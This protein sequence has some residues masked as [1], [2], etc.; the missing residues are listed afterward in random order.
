MTLASRQRAEAGAPFADWI[1]PSNMSVQSLIDRFEP[2][3]PSLTRRLAIGDPHLVDFRS[4]D[5]LGMTRHPALRK[6]L[7]AA[8]ATGASGAA[9]SPL[10]SGWTREHAALA[11]RVSDT[12][13]TEDT[14]LFTS[15]Y[16]ANLTLMSAL[17]KPGD[18][19]LVDRETH[20]SLL[21]GLKL[22]GAR[23]RRY[24]HLDTAHLAELMDRHPAARAIVTDGLFSMSGQIAPLAQILDLAEPRRL[25]VI[26]DDAH[27]FGT[28]G[29]RG[30]GVTEFAGVD[31]RRLAA[32]TGTFGKS[33]GLGG[34][35]VT[36]SRA[37]TDHLVQSGRGF[38]YST[39]MPTLFAEALR[40]LW[41]AVLLDPAPR[42]RLSLNIQTFRACCQKRGLPVENAPGPIQPLLLGDPTKA[43][44]VAEVARDSGFALGAFRPPT[45]APGTSR[46]R[47]ALSAA[48]TRDA[49][50][51]LTNVLADAVT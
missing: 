14:L 5:Y 26:L 37:L 42:D 12:F 3:A 21:D 18:D 11:D 13:G 22:A 51:N 39:A 17:F 35:F 45:V 20:A 25:P 29:Q 4:N 38:I 28:L 40:L 16:A 27:G 36:G 44:R 33:F 10:V 6:A 2:V 9:A 46:I 23:I 8:V 50:E 32:L 24:R 47:I 34:A 49:I 48:H 30:L 19:V 7:E 31:P 15:G 43:L 41:P 1:P